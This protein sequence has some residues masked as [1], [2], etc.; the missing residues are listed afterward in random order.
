MF[1]ALHHNL[2]LAALRW[3]APHMVPSHI[4]GI[5]KQLSSHQQWVHRIRNHYHQHSLVK[6]ASVSSTGS[7]RAWKARTYLLIPKK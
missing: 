5:P 1:Q 2:A 3:F 4:S 7:S 6:A